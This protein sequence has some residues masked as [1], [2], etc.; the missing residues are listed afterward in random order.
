MHLFYLKRSGDGGRGSLE[1]MVFLVKGWELNVI[2]LDH[3]C[4]TH[5]GAGASMVFYTLQKNL[6][7]KNIWKHL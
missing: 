6:P 4:E 1:M 7:N 3:L 2:N 5:P